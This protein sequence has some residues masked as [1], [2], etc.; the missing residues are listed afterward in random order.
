[1]L[2]NFANINPSLYGYCWFRFSWKIKLKKIAIVFDSLS[3]YG[4]VNWV[5]KSRFDKS[6]Q[7]A[8]GLKQMLSVIIISL[9]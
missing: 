5:F 9:L 3:L 1:M 2:G 4:D 8:T 6:K 7:L